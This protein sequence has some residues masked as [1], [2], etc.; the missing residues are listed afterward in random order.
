MVPPSSKKRDRAEK[1]PPYCPTA[2]PGRGTF[3]SAARSSISRLR[4]SGWPHRTGPM[5]VS[6]TF[7]CG[8][9]NQVSGNFT[10]PNALAVARCGSRATE[11]PV[12][13]VFSR[14]ASTVFQ[15]VSTET[16][17]TSIAGSPF[18][19]W[20]YSRRLGSSSTHGGHQVAQK[21][22]IRSLPG[23]LARSRDLPSR[24]VTGRGPAGVA[25]STGTGLGSIDSGFGLSRSH[26]EA[27]AAAA[28]TTPIRMRRAFGISMAGT[29]PQ[30][31]WWGTGHP[32]DRPDRTPLAV[33]AA[34]LPDALRQD[35]EPRQRPI[36]RDRVG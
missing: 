4:V 27:P 31:E 25:W 16:A 24:S 13:F 8:S 3:G 35:S 2:P 15:S 30:M 23:A 18:T 22:T 32:A 33:G 21:W 6:T 28:T 14:K 17:R 19:D 26:Q 5:N 1:V 9:R 10:V 29:L 36:E 20:A 34:D 7:P 12:A 11:S